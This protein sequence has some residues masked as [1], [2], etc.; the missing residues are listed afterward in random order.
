MAKK[1]EE[2]IVTRL[3]ESYSYLSVDHAKTNQAKN[4]NN[5]AQAKYTLIAFILPN[6]TLLNAKS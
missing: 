5:P 1:I 3:R 4:N 2:P 6:T